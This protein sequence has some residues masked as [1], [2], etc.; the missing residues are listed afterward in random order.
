MGEKCPYAYRGRGVSLRCRKLTEKT[1]SDYC[2]HQFLCRVSRQW[3]NTAEAAR[4]PLRE[5]TERSESKP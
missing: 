4:C 1:S 3:E 2:G 5:E